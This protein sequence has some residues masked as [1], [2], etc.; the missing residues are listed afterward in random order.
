MFFVCYRYGGGPKIIY[1]P[2]V[3]CDP[4]VCS[5]CVQAREYQENYELFHFKNRYKRVAHTFTSL[6]NRPVIPQLID[7]FIS[8]VYVLMTTGDSVDVVKRAPGTKYSLRERSMYC[9]FLLK[10]ILEP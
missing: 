6:L 3:F 5:S 4:Q 9:Y 7:S 10:G 2:Q 1:I 8:F